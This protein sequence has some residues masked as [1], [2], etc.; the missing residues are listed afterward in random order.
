LIDTPLFAYAT[1]TTIGVVS[2]AATNLDNLVLLVTIGSGARRRRAAIAGFVLASAV[3]LGLS[4]AGA[5]LPNL[6]SPKALGYL[7]IVPILLG[8][9]LMLAGP[10]AFE[11]IAV[12]AAAMPVAALLIGNSGDTIAAFAPLF[13]ESARAM[14]FAVAAGFMLCATAWLLLLA[15]VSHR[16]EAA[17]RSSPTFRR[18]AHR[19]SAATM[20]AVGA[21]ILWDSGTDT[22]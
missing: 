21:Y 16:A 22:L 9:R 2:Y 20:I 11:R 3:V 14:R 17:F 8:L 4:L 6:L 13:A 19:I 10:A 15:G 12:D 1:A 5:L 18:D 7:G